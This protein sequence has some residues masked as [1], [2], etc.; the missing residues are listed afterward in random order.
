[1]KNGFTRLGLITSQAFSIGNF[2]GPLIRELV[3]QG[4]RVYA[5]APDYDDATRKAVK[6][7]DAEPVDY[8]MQRAGISITRDATGMLGLARTLHRLRLDVTLAYFVKPVIY[9]SFAAWMAGIRRRFSIVEGLG[10]VFAEDGRLDSFRRRA[11]RRVVSLMYRRA[12]AINE[13]VFFLNEEDINEFLSKR[14]IN[15]EKTVRLNGIGV[16]LKYYEP[17]PVVKRPVTFILAA[18]LLKEKGV[19]DYISAA[20]RVLS[21]YPDTRFLLVGGE[22]PNPGSVTESEMRQWVDEGIV[23]W[24]NHVADVRPWIAEASVYVLPSYYREGV[25]RGNQEAMAMGRPVITTDWV[26]CRETVENGVNGFLV[27]TRDPGAVSEAM[28]RFIRK[29][30]L[31]EKMGVKGRRM[32]EIKFNAHEINRIIMKEMGLDKGKETGV[33]I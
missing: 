23:E 2:R 1:M 12:S 5:F 25:P 14:L 11:L 10:Y 27:P 7:L 6:A 17:V 30:D 21:L 26:G 15:R 8:S 28:I 3:A 16:D 33:S 20:R 13:K 22:D 9:G 19:Y 32:A 18:R 31:I 24:Q 29:P 4:V